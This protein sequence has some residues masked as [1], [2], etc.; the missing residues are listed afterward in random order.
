MTIRFKVGI[1]NLRNE[2]YA[3]LPIHFIQKLKH[4]FYVSKPVGTAIGVKEDVEDKYQRLFG[5]TNCLNFEETS[6]RG[7]AK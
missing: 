6:L 1:L 2:A 3:N 7:H 4:D 5:S